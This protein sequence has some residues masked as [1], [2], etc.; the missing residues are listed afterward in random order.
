[1]PIH[2][3]TLDILVYIGNSLRYFTK[4]DTNMLGRGI[5]PLHAFVLKLIS[6]KGCLIGFSLIGM[7]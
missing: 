4:I 5:K 7:A 3:L 2:L 1:M 6:T